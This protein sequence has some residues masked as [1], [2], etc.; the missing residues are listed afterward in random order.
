MPARF[1]GFTGQQ[2]YLMRDLLGLRKLQE[3]RWQ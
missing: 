3:K 1:V 2:M